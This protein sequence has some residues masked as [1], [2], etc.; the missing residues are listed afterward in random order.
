VGS[1]NLASLK[2]RIYYKTLNT[3]RA[4]AQKNYISKVANFVNK[5]EVTYPSELDIK[6]NQRVLVLAPHADD[7]SIGCGGLLLKY[8]SNIRVVCLSDGRYGDDEMDMLT[9]IKTRKEEFSNAMQYANIKEFSF[10]DIED[11]KVLE[12]FDKFNRI[13]FTDYDYI[14]L[15]NYLDQHQDH[16]AVAKLLKRALKDID[17]ISNLKICFY[18]VWSTLPY[19]NSFIDLSSSV[20]QKR[21]LIKFYASQM[22]YV[23]YDKRILALNQYRGMLPQKEFA[24]AYLVV[25][26]ESFFKLID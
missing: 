13:N 5:L 23:K 18:E 24:E 22:K 20:E 10:L 21:E 2:T 14:F 12:G 7:E 19:V 1:S 16:K 26:I 8:N 3:I 11:S 17:D 25:D 6:E 15:P 4:I 9:L